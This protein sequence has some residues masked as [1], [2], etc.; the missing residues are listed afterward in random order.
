MKG[1]IL[2]ILGAVVAI[3]V[4]VFLF[5]PFDKLGGGDSYTPFP[6]VD[7]E[8][9][10]TECYILPELLKE[11]ELFSQEADAEVLASDRVL[12]LDGQLGEDGTGYLLCIFTGSPSKQKMSVE[13]YLEFT[14]FDG[15]A[16]YY[17]DECVEY[18]RYEHDT[19]GTVPLVN[20]SKPANERLSGNFDV[21][22]RSYI[23]LKFQVKREGLLYVDCRIEPTG[24]TNIISIDSTA[25][26]SYKTEASTLGKIED[27]S[28]GYLSSADYN[29]GQFSDTAIKRTASFADGTEN[30]MVIDLT[31]S[32]TAD[33]SGGEYVTILSGISKRG[34]LD[35]TIESAPTSRINEVKTQD[36]IAISASFS[37]PAKAKE[38]KTIRYILRLLPVSGGNTAVDLFFVGMGNM[39]YTTDYY[40]TGEPL[41]TYTLSE[42]GSHYT[43]TGCNATA[44]DITILDS[45]GDK[46]PV[47]AI[48]PDVFKGNTTIKR[49]VI[50]NNIE[51]IEAETF[52]DCEN[53]S[54]VV[55]GTRVSY[56]G[57]EAFG[58]KNS[59]ASGN[60]EIK[61]LAAWCAVE[62]EGNT[63]SPFYRAAHISQP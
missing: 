38:K 31:Y 24:A 60:F 48:A 45:L 11:R 17:D 20:M 30:Y 50:G 42:D 34:V 54:Q 22:K 10:R 4:T 2:I 47:T 19:Y 28:I 43:V 5:V 49:V 61:D 37:L 12:E 56:I 62:L 23:I 44:S 57:R 27:L 3:A 6:P 16:L 8:G 52:Y 7:S 33:N 40:Q 55:M 9:F 14:L 53:L 59:L 18:L 51:R 41:L 39:P 25:T 36:G 26:A 35:A 1:K 58:G 32:A 21:R 63:S 15:E 13:T 46:K 29:Q